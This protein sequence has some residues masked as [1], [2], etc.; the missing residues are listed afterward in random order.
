VR[1]AILIKF[2]R[3]GKYSSPETVHAVIGALNEFSDFF[4]KCAREIQ[5]NQAAKEAKLE[6]NKKGVANE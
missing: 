4:S 2:A 3:G 6:A 5:I 1:D